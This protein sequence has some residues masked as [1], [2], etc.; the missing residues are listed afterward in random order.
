[1]NRISWVQIGVFLA[2]VAGIFLV[3]ITV[4]AFVIGWPAGVGP[5]GPGMMGG[6][7][8]QG[9]CPFCGGTGRYGGGM[10][11]GVY[12]WLFPLMLLLFP[13]GILVLIAL[14]IVWL[15]RSIGSSRSQTDSTTLKCPKCGK[16]VEVDWRVC[17]FCE[18]DLQQLR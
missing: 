17:P 18:E 5:M 10:Y 6:G 1:M 8:T 16:S 15:V 4:L 11:G 3:G 13:L 7:R 14:G 2:I 12:G 9:W